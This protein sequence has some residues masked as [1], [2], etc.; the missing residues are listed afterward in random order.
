MAEPSLF[1]QTRHR[2]RLLMISN[3]RR[4]SLEVRMEAMALALSSGRS[5]VQMLIERPASSIIR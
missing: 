3:S 5:F 2:D 4:A 1:G